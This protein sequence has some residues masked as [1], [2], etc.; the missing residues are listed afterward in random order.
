MGF[1]GA[2]IYKFEKT[3]FNPA[4]MPKIRNFYAE[5]GNEATS[6]S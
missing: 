4:F 1:S 3:S 6:K 2:I 5:T